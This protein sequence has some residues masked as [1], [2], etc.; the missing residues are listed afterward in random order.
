ANVSDGK[1]ACLLLDRMPAKDFP[2]LKGACGDGRYNEKAFV[3][4]MQKRKLHLEVKTRP[5]GSKGFVLLKQRWIV[6]RTF[7]W[8]STH[9]RLS[10]DYEKTV[11][12]SEA[13]IKIAGISMMLRRLNKCA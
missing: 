6:E 7:A 11:A 10:K 4:R 2:R 3:W 8:L 13:R 5:P 1:G 12:S 9:R